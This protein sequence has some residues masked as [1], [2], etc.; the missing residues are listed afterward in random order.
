MKYLAVQQFSGYTVRK[1]R[2]TVVLHAVYIRTY[3]YTVGYTVK[4]YD[5]VYYNYYY[6]RYFQIRPRPILYPKHPYL[7]TPDE[8]LTNS[9]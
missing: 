4:R 8:Y 1:W 9:S 7:I 6:N 2:S 5:I 3:V